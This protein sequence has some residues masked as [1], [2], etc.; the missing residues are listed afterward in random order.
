MTGA[1]TIFSNLL[2]R[3]TLHITS[4]VNHLTA[5]M[6][7]LLTNPSTL[8]VPLD[9]Y[10]EAIALWLTHILVD[11]ALWRQARIKGRVDKCKGSVMAECVAAPNAWSMQV[12]RAL[13][14]KSLGSEDD[15]DEEFGVRWSALV[16]A[17]AT[18]VDEI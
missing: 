10:R 8:S 5:A 6:T 7:N 11:N 14:G 3:L 18:A 16:E 13:V 15:G 12:A 17:A 9:S 4:F 2:R 1:F